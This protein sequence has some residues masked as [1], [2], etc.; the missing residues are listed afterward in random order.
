[1]PG[2]ASSLVSPARALAESTER[3]AM[4]ARY[5][6]T[7]SPYRPYSRYR[8]EPGAIGGYCADRWQFSGIRL[9]KDQ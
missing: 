3:E 8:P 9:A 4:A 2:Q 7:D 1:M 5:E 6:W